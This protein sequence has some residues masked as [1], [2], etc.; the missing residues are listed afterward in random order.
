MSTKAKLVIGLISVACI[1][2][3]ILYPKEF[4]GIIVLV[5]VVVIFA[6]LRRGKW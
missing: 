2:A 3:L 6:T 5:V 1:V 4:F